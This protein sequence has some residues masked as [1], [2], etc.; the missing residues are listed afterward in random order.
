MANQKR[1]KIN[2]KRTDNYIDGSLCL[3]SSDLWRGQHSKFKNAGAGS[4]AAAGSSIC[5]TEQ[6]A[7]RFEYMNSEDAIERLPAK[8]WVW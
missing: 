7:G 4:E 5:R 8:S 1:Q 3:L 2:V 6:P